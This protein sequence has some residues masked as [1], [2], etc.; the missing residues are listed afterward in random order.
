MD[1]AHPTDPLRGY[2]AHRGVHLSSTLAGENSL[3]GIDYAKR[4]GFFCIETDCRYT[5]DSALVIIHDAYLNRTFLNAD[6]TPLTDTIRVADLTLEQFQTSYV[7]K[8]QR[9]EFQTAAPTLKEYLQK[10]KKL[11]FRVFI[12]PKLKDATGRYYLDIIRTADEVLG[13]DGY[14]ITSN[15]YANDIIRNT[16]RIDDVRLMGLLFKS[17]FEEM[18]ALGNTIYA[19]SSTAFT[20]DEYYA[21]L[22]RAVSDGRVVQ[23]AEV[24]RGQSSQKRFETFMRLKNAKKLNYI[25]T[26]YAAPDYHGQGQKLLHARDMRTLK[27]WLREAPKVEFGGIYIDLVYSGDCQI[28]CSTDCFKAKG[29]ASE[30]SHISYQRMFFDEKPEVAVV[31]DSPDFAIKSIDIKI[32]KF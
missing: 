27:K 10:C 1:E 15:N 8:A 28:T 16:L 14:V 25:A 9:K 32:I 22:S 7:L 21:N 29:K 19:V 5:K 17:S 6:G 20:E 4:A 23:S 12:E 2:M 24:L 11:G 30:L 31:A 13:R 18:D 26:D 3:E